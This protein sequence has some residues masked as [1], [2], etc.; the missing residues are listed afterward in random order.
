M[1]RPRLAPLPLPRSLLGRLMLILAVGLFVSQALAFGLVFYE[2]TQSSLGLMMRYVGKDV[3]SSVAILEQEAPDHRA[4]WLQRLDRRNYRYT[5]GSAAPGDVVTSAVAL[6]I[7]EAIAESL[8]PGYRLRA[9]ELHDEHNR[10]LLQLQLHDG[11][12]L[13]LEFTLMP[14]PLSPWMIT[15]LCLQLLLLVLFGWLAVRWVT[16]PLT[17]LARAADTL[18]TDF[19]PR[20]LKEAGPTE[21]AR[22]TRAFNLMQR[23]INDHLKE[24]MQILAAISHDLQTPIT[25]MRLRADLLDDADLRERLHGDLDAM[26]MLVTDGIAYARDGQGVTELPCRLD[27]DALLDSLVDDYTSSGKTVALSGSLGEPLVTRPNTLRRIVVNLIDNALK[28]GHDAEVRIQRET[29]PGDV[30]GDHAGLDGVAVRIL[31]NG[32][33]IPETQLQAVLQPFYRLEH[34]RNRDTGG[35]GLGLAIAQQ[36]THALGGRLQLENRACGGLAARIWLP[37]ARDL[38]LVAINTTAATPGSRSGSA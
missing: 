17:R 28:F 11:S 22:A 10:L 26:Q 14:V 5:L 13:T 38:D 36:L 12:P 15:A 37:L 4:E 8:G 24:R 33:G 3:A 31:D 20:P 34:S 2:R 32:P 16:G 25:R 9:T 21:V 29:V 19:V 23:R 35:S 30:Q 6:R 18:A 27:L 7:V 1:A